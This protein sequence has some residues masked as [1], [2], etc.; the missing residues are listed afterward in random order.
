[1]NDVA[2]F[3]LERLDEQVVDLYA[4]FL[5][6]QVFDAHMHMYYGP[7]CPKAVQPQSVFDREIATV[8]MYQKDMLPFLPGV[9]VLNM[10]MIPMPDPVLSDL[11]SGSRE[12]AHGHIL[13]EL[14]QGQGNTGCAYVLPCDT[15]E[16]IDVLTSYP[17]IRGIKCYS[18]GAGQIETE[19][20]PVE[21]Y[22]PEAAWVVANQKK[23]PIILHM[24]RPHALSDEENFAYICQMTHRYPNAQLVLAHCARGSASWTVV[25]KIK[26]LEDQ[27][28][29]WFDLSAICEAGPIMACI[30]KNAGKRTMWGSDYPICMSRGRPVS[31]AGKQNWL[32]G[33]NLPFSRTYV[34]AEN[35][36]AL[37]EAAVILDLDKPQIE[38]LFFNNAKALFACLS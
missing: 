26:Q 24:M 10:N 9:D 29:I 4:D 20:L 34:L 13:K 25:N 35:L 14:N 16:T 22:L 31:V 12:V 33:K 8:Q 1:M 18:Y 37:H 7:A 32:T 38:D 27:G 17:G 3:S 15:E 23:L 11:H 21:K 6:K 36:L 5:P 30:M 2:R 28:N 19:S